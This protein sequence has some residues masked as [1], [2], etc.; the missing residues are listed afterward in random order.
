MQTMSGGMSR[1][2]KIGV[3]LALIAGLVAAWSLL[4]VAAWIEAFRTWVQQLGLLGHV[5]FVVAYVIATVALAPASALTLAAGVAFGLAGFPTVIIG[6]T[7]GAGAAFLVG[8][9]VARD[10]VERQMAGSPIFKAI[11]KAIESEGWKIVGLMR[12]SP[13]VPFNLQ[14]YFFGATKV[15]FWPY[16]ITSFFGIMPGTLLFVWIGSLG[17]SAGL[18][19]GAVQA[20]SGSAGTIKLIALGVGLIATAAVTVIVSRKASQMLR[21]AGVETAASARKAA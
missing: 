6:A 15:G 19:G 9:H 13:L 1:A 8:R 11:D 21:E 2:I 3:G 10:W 4:P 17:A 12:L 7:L 14:N 5:V 18:S 20:A 16:L